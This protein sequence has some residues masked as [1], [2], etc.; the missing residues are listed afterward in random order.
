MHSP[1]E[2]LKM[3]EYIG[4][5]ALFRSGAVLSESNEMKPTFMERII[6]RLGCI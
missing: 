3:S 5:K 2:I 1:S 4:E 6:F